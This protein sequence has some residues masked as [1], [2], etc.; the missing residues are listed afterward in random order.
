MQ[1]VILLKAFDQCQDV[2]NL[3]STCDQ[4]LGYEGFQ[5]GFS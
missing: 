2:V 3:P 1:D 5:T 4:D